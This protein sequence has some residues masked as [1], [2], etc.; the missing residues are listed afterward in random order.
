[1]YKDLHAN[2]E[3]SMQERRTA[4]IAADW[5][6]NHGYDVADEIGGTGVTGVLR[7]GDGPVVLLRADMDALPVTETTGL[8]HA[9]VATGVDR[10]GQ[11]TGIV[12]AVTTCIWPDSWARAAFSP[13]TKRSGKEP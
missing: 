3:L 6:K 13:K 1:V 4:K 12:H 11:T 8:G 10:F 5:L 2:P 9:S 7:N